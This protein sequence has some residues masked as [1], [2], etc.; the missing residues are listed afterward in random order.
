[1]F[2]PICGALS[3]PDSKNNI[4]CPD[5]KCGYEGPLSGPDGKG[6][7]FI[8]PMSGEEIDLTNA[9]AKNATKSLKHLTEVVEEEVARGT[10]R[11]GDYICPNCEE[12][13]VYVWMQQ[14]RSSDEP[15][16]KMCT[17]ESC[18]KKWREYQ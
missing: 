7:K 5:Y 6:G 12:N 17:C 13:R 11:V 9:T 10:L 16:T 14:T 8:D 4:K 3:F 18:N 15:E 1:M 2:C